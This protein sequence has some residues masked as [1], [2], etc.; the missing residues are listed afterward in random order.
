LTFEIQEQICMLLSVGNTVETSCTL[1]GIS[2]DT[3]YTWFNKGGASE[4]GIHFDFSEA[5]KKA[6]T[7]AEA[8]HVR[9]IYQGEKNWQ[10]SA[11]WLER[12]NPK[13]RLPRDFPP[14]RPETVPLDEM[15]AVVNKALDEDPAAKE[16]I[17]RVLEEMK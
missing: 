3:F 7:S 10:S 15:I 1:A 13:Y 8:H 16:R 4:N 9:R 11:W 14:E 6:R 2:V 12:T 5:V 17:L